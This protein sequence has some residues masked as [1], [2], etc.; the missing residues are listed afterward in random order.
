ML[1]HAI[2]VKKKRSAFQLQPY[3]QP[4]NLPVFPKIK[5][6][7]MHGLPLD[8]GVTVLKSESDV[9]TYTVTGGG[10]IFS[11]KNTSNLIT[12]RNEVAAR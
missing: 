6:I 12:A 10:P 5:E 8:Y 3:I 7:F 11:R 2:E 1:Y 4:Y 9:C